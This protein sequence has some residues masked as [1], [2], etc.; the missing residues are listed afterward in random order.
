MRSLPLSAL[1]LAAVSLAAPPAAAQR[2]GQLPPGTARPW[3]HEASDV[4]VHPGIR[5]GHL[6]NGLRYALMDH[7]IPPGRLHLRLH[8][9]AG[10]LVERDAER[11]MAH[12]LQHMAFE[13]S[14]AFTREELAAWLADE[15]LSTEPDERASTD[16]GQSV[17]HLVLRGPDEARLRRALAFLRDVADGLDLEP[18]RVQAVKAAVD[19]EERE[20]LALPENRLLLRTWE[21]LFAG[22]RV[23]ERVPLGARDARTAFSSEGLRAFWERWYR[24][25]NLT[26]VV[27]GDLAA[28]EGVD[29]EALVRDQFSDVPLADDPW[30]PAPG[31]GA[32]DVSPRG[33]SVYEPGVERVFV[34]VD[35]LVPERGAPTTRASLLAD[36]PL[37]W[38]RRLFSL[39]LAASPRAAELYEHAEA[40]SARRGLGV[41]DG[42]SLSITTDARRWRA[43]L[44]ACSALLERTLAEGFHPEELEALRRAQIAAMESGAEEE[45]PSGSW[46]DEILASIEHGG[47]PADPAALRELQLPRI[48]ELSVEELRDAWRASWD[49]GG[50]VLSAGG[51]LDLGARAEDELLEAF[52]AARAGSAAAPRPA[53]PAAAAF[54]YDSREREPGEV[55]ERGPV[56]GTGATSVR[57][58]NGARLLVRAGGEPSDQVLVSVRCGAGMLSLEP[59]RA[60]LAWVAEQVFLAGGLGRHDVAQLARLTAGRQLEPRFSVRDD[61]FE[62]FVATRRDDLRLACEVLAAYVA[63]PGWREE[64]L[65][66]LHKALPDL[67]RQVASDARGALVERFEPALYGG[68]PRFG[69]PEQAAV[70][71]VQADDL[72]AWL[73]PE[74]A[75]AALTVTIVGDVD[76]DAAAELAARTFGRLPPRAPYDRHEDRRATPPLATSLRHEARIP[77]ARATTL[78]VV[79]PTTDGRDPRTRHAL[80]LLARA[81]SAR[82]QQTLD[83]SVRCTAD[84]RASTTY[85]GNGHI[86]LRAELPP[87]AADATLA[88]ILA[89]AD[90][91]AREG[92]T[93]EELL[94][95]RA[96]TLDQLQEL[97]TQTPYWLA[98]LAELHNRPEALT[99]TL[100]APKTYASLTP[101]DLNPLAARYL[102]KTRASTLIVRPQ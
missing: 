32:G 13:G 97:P 45:L 23:P 50:L 3:P 26:V 53:A 15:G 86:G 92:L 64:G 65:A 21:R 102:D 47:V 40:A 49:R 58:E 79:F 76:A 36:L 1:L 33:F 16:F 84:S 29:V 74:L 52:R 66:Q 61:F 59:A 56:A 30:T 69:L 94:P 67:Y 51:D 41:F 11:G 18:E 44:A 91:L 72:R 83:P 71:S 98:T 34:T 93:A 37:A 82:L 95:L 77:G 22:T 42:E 78:Y 57:F 100:E 101:E 96:R 27:V 43:A 70:R 31:P 87:T 54:A 2:A 6:A 60:P 35:S 55:V 80:S 63:D 73:A 7:A 14:R 39:R 20:R 99:E 88:K 46:A 62:L 19:R 8:V 85:E 25:E 12:F 5:F 28:L 9:D 81:L 75:G 48:R 4:P 24:P 68:D 38:A 17:Y 90:T 89:T 10:S